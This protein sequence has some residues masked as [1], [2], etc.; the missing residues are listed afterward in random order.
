ML[1]NL[2][3]LRVGDSARIVALMTSGE[4]RRRLLDIGFVPEAEVTCLFSGFSGDPRAYLIKNTVIA[5]RS[6]DAETIII[7]KGE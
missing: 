7:Q 4:M 3:Q 6:E 5:L 1:S 2:Y